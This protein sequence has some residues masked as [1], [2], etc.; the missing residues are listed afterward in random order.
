VAR[1]AALL[2]TDAKKVVALSTLR[3]LGLIF[4][5]FSLGNFRI[6]LLHVLVH[7]LAKSNLFLVV[8]SVLHN[9]FAQQDSRSLRDLRGLVLILRAM[10]RVFGLV[11]ILFISRFFSKEQILLGH[12]KIVSSLT[13]LFLLLMISRVTLSYCLK[14]ILVISNLGLFSS[15]WRNQRFSKTRNMPLALL[16]SATIIFGFFLF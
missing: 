14:L 6:S 10:I 11:G 12:Y 13:R 15:V 7:A 9:R 2:E 4:M 1:T 3:Q 8:G 5:A 16:G